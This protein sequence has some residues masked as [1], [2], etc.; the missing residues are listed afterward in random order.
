MGI[1]S[2]NELHQQK[3]IN[4]IF[5]DCRFFILS[6]QKNI[7]HILAFFPSLT[8]IKIYQKTSLV[9]KKFNYMC[10]ISAIYAINSMEI[11]KNAKNVVCAI[12]TLLFLLPP[13]TKFRI[14]G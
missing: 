1:I 7:L 10:A 12:F 11:N 2:I 5:H 8:I 13:I 9:H 14:L 3:I 4:A 6:F